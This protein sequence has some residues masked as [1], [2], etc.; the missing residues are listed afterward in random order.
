R[1]RHSCPPDLSGPSL[2]T[3]GEGV[4]LLN[5]SPGPDR[6]PGG[7]KVPPPKTWVSL[8][9]YCANDSDCS[10]PSYKPS[11]DN[12]CVKYSTT[13]NGQSNIWKGGSQ[14]CTFPSGVSFSWN[15][16]SDAQSQPNYAN[17]G[18]GSNNYRSFAGFK[19]D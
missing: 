1:S 11:P 13:Y 14:S 12:V 9:V 16:R 2:A 3:R 5:C 4:H 10:N 6:D 19:D 8:V 17:V 7:S 18:S 15:I